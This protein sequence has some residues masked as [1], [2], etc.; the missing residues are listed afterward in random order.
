MKYENKDLDIKRVGYMPTVFEEKDHVLT[1]GGF[2]VDFL[3][4]D[5][6]YGDSYDRM[7]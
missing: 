6:A 4:R 3:L 2:S 7:R 5:T 1:L